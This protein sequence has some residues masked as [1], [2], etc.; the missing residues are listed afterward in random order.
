[1]MFSGLAGRSNTLADC[2][3][4]AI[5]WV[6]L[7]IVGLA[8]LSGCAG[9]IGAAGPPAITVSGNGIMRG[10]QPWWLT[11]FNSFV[12]SGDCGH[13]YERMST[14]DVDTWF[15]SMRHDGHG[16]VRLF[17]FEGWS[18]GRLDAAVMSAKRNNV[19]LTITLANGIE[20]C[21]EREKDAGWFDNA[22]DRAD[23]ERHLSTLVERYRGDTAI[24]WFEYFNE[25]RYVGGKLRQF[26]DEMGARAKAIDPQR[27]FASGTIAP[28]SLGGDGN[29]L[30]ASSSPGVDI[31]S[32]HE[33][34]EDEGESN[35][36][37]SVRANAAGKPIIVGEFGIM[38][39]DEA[40][41][42]LNFADRAERVAAKLKAYTTIPGYIGAF[43]WAWSPGNGDT[44]S[45]GNLASDSALQ[46][47]LRSYTQ[48]VP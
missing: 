8:A 25:P 2:R 37:P 32:L 22:Q 15:A 40:R 6:V 47:V 1:M 44:C 28:Y 46:S 29:F 38:A 23:Y 26:F 39:S 35:Q 30:D 17:F 7:V 18:L 16:A 45:I 4:A 19:Y 34:D 13:D 48:A 20:G 31:V 10:G 43:A 24:A 5:R 14:E 11:G 33:Y 3:G 42:R 21:G 9:P 12:W 41:C 27:L 36:G